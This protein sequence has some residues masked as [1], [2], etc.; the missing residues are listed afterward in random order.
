MP[1]SDASPF[2]AAEECPSCGSSATR[3]IVYGMPS[4]DDW[5]RAEAGEF[6]IAGC[7]IPE[8][9][10]ASWCSNCHAEF[11]VWDHNFDD[12]REDAD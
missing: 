3:P 5:A 6:V 7:V 1:E 8:R 9:P 12:L 11:G 2:P 4:L 10:A